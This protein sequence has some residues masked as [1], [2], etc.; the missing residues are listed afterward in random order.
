MRVAVAATLFDVAVRDRINFS[1]PRTFVQLSVL[2]A[3]GSNERSNTPVEW[4]F[5]SRFIETR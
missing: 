4:S 2:T 5:W 3:H 1:S